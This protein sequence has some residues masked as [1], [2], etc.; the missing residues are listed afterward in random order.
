[1]KR[2]TYLLAGM[3][4]GGF[5]VIMSLKYHVLRTNDGVTLVPKLSNSF[6][7]AYVDVREFGLTDWAAHQSLT[8]AI[9]KSNKEHI[10]QAAA[11]QSA[12]RQINEWMSGSPR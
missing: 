12:Q 3:I 2:I 10:L 9:V 5:V 6:E 1:M 7:H 11:Q 4:L 8:A